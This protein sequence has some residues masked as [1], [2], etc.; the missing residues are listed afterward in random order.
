MLR[1]IEESL[2]RLGTD[3]LDVVLVHD[4]DDHEDDALRTAFPALVELRDEGVVRRSGAA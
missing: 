4:P 3:R 1:S 2:T